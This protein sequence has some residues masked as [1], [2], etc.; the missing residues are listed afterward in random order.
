M[1][2]S[3]FGWPH[4]N[5]YGLNICWTNFGPNIFL[6]HKFVWFQISFGPDIVLN[7]LFFWNYS[8]LTQNRWTTNFIDPKCNWH[9]W[10]PTIFR[11][12]NF[13]DTNFCRTQI[14]LEHNFLD[15][16]FFEQNIFGPTFF[17]GTQNLLDSQFFWTHNLWPQN[18]SNIKL[19]RTYNFLDPKF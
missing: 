9:F 11:T 17:L 2:T 14:F 3:N 18:S 10:D 1:L 6:D 13:L 19:L 4:K 12:H 5:L 8:C 15:P 16:K 7:P